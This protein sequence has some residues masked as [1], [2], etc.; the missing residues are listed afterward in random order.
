MNS[1]PNQSLAL[2]SLPNPLLMRD[3]GNIGL[4]VVDL[5]IEVV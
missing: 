4:F 2:D 1:H 3:W 5:S